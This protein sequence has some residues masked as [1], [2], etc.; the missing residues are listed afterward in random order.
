MSFFGDIAGAVIGAVAGRNSDRENKLAQER[1]NEQNL[2]LSREQMAKQEEFAKNGIRWKVEDA[3]AAGLHPLYA[4]GG[5]GASYTPSAIPVQAAGGSSWQKDFGQNLGRAVTAG[6]DSD[7]RELQAAQLDAIR[8]GTAKDLALAQAAASEDQRAWMDR[9]ISRPINLDGMGVRPSPGWGLD[10]MGQ[11]VD[12]PRSATNGQ[13][14]VLGNRHGMKYK[15]VERASH[16][17]GN[18]SE[19][20]GRDAAFTRYAITPWGLTATAPSSTEGYSEAKE[21]EWWPEFLWR[22]TMLG[23]P[24]WLN[25]Y[26][27]QYILGKAPKFR[28]MPPPSSFKHKGGYGRGPG[29]SQ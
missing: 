11:Q 25:Q 23:G 18:E 12:F 1:A 27:Q 26:V 14:A 16:E 24:D 8:A 21:S 28:Q 15:S 5:S 29:R 17:P 6:L 22:N 4:L 13:D 7:A 10:A 9:W 2:A 19:Q 3:R 20:R